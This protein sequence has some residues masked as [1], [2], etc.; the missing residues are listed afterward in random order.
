MNILIGSHYFHPHLGGIESVVESHAKFLAERGHNITILTSCVDTT[1]MHSLQDGYRVLRYNAWNP[2]E[3]IGVPYPIPH[4]IDAKNKIKKIFNSNDID[5]VHTHGMN[6]LTTLMLLKY[7]PSDIPT[8]LHQHTPFVEYKSP[9]SIAEKINDNIISKWN[10]RQADTV[11]CVS[12][13]IENYINNLEES[14]DTKI[15]TNGVDL[16]N[17]HPKQASMIEGFDCS[18]NT[19]VFFTLS[20]MSQKKGVDI[21]LEAI[22]NIDSSRINAHFAVAGDGP[23]RAEV[24]KTAKKVDNMETLGRVSDDELIGYYAASDA[25]LFTSKSGEAFP[26]LTMIEAYASGTPVIGSKIG[27][28]SKIVKNGWNSILVEPD[29]S[30]QLTTAIKKLATDDRKLS[31][32]RTRARNSAEQYLSIN[33]RIDRLE[34]HYES[35]VSSS[36]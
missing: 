8:V 5:L 21:L 15:M 33:S 4:P 10:L 12:K 2:L 3:E 24:E 26:T 32:M 30:N 9:L 18:S 29:N 28:N 7:M 31:E 27:K 36:N 11:F 17:Y 1:S 34:S 14:V 6:Y 20:R 35:L 25:F 22:K 23:M 13:N 19:P 16:S